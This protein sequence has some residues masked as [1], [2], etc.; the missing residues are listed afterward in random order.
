MSKEILILELQGTPE[1]FMAL[2]QFVKRAG[3]KEFRENAKGDT[4]AYKIRDAVS[5]LQNALGR[6]GYA[7]R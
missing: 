2:A 1:K 6:A 4:E 7:P 5:E 3:W